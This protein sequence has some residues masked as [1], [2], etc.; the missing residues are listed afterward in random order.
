[1]QKRLVLTSLVAVGCACPIFAARAEEFPTNGYMLENKTYDEA[2]TYE[3]MGVY[4]G[5]VTATAEYEDILY[6][7]AAGTYLPAGAT[8]AEQCPANSYCPGIKDATYN[9]S[10]AQ[11]ATSCPDGYP[12]S[13]AGASRDKQCYTACTV[14][15]ANIA[16]ATAVSGNDYY[17]TGVDTCGATECENGYHVEDVIKVV[18]QTPL[19]DG[20]YTEAGGIIMG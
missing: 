1:M 5:T 7:I 11:G 20:D 16:H 13:V 2:A 18:E 14:G 8:A 4:D 17:D 12:N 6:Q 9:E 19:I 15:S 10:A 3:N